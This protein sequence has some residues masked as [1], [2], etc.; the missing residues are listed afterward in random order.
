ML[1]AAQSMIAEYQAETPA[2]RRV[3]ERVPADRLDFRP[4]EK[5]MCLGQLAYHVAL[6]PGRITQMAMAGELDA[7]KVSFQPPMPE[8]AAELL[9]TLEASVATACDYLAGLD[10]AMAASPFRL[11]MGEK[12]IFSMP[13]LGLMRT[14]AM[15]HWYH[16]RGQ[17]LVYLRLLDVPVPT[18]YGRTADENPFA[19]VA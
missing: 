9:P 17:V 8:S 12:E 11:T 4:H 1:T 19:E 15:N 6:I 2:T 13:R 14:L 3:L 5:S 10:E 16:H 18:V 7:S